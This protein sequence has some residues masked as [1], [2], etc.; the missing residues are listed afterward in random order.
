MWCQPHKRAT[1]LAREGQ[2]LVT[3]SVAEIISEGN[4][5]VPLQSLVSMLITQKGQL[6]III[7]LVHGMTNSL[8]VAM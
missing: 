5:R 6:I 7:L 1:A 3:E 4:N 8:E 2:V